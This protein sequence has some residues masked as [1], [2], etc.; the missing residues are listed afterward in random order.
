MLLG[1]GLALLLGEPTLTWEA[2]LHCP[3]REVA[4]E[5]LEHYLGRSL[6]EDDPPTDMR[7][8]EAAGGYRLEL[9]TRAGA[10]VIEGVDCGRLTQLAASVAA[11]AI[12]PL[13]LS[14][15][16]DPPTL[17][18]VEPE[19]APIE[20]APAIIEAPLP[21]PPAIEPTPIERPRPDP[22]PELRDWRTTQTPVDEGPR[23]R[24]DTRLRGLLSASAGLGLAVFPRP[25]PGFEA[26]VGLDRGAL[27]LELGG[28]GWFAGQFRSSSGEVGG[29]LRAWQV[30]VRPCGVP[31]WRRVELRLCGARRGSGPCARSR[32]ARSADRPPALG[33]PGR[34]ARPGGGAAS[35]R[36]A[37][38]RRR[39]GGQPGPPAV[40]DRGPGVRVGDPRAVGP[41]ALRPRST[42]SLTSRAR[43][44]HPPA[45]DPENQL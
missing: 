13:A 18:R 37:L 11:I 9:H 25:A 4:A 41:R 44:G 5:A 12:D 42:I 19:R 23:L 3:S 34:R 24:H 31:R 29:D 45:I 15:P 33:V 30:G 26:G 8:R 14:M 38:R 17:A 20:V 28:G 2:P 32:R 22:E 35:Q 10:H 36:R 39:R 27:H 21:E 16:F 1:V 43:P 7:V 6:A 40:L